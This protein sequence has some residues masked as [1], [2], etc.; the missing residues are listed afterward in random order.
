MFSVYIFAYLICLTNAILLTRC[1]NI[2]ILSSSVMVPHPLHI[3]PTYCMYE[4]KVTILNSYSLKTSEMCRYCEQNCAIPT[5]FS[6]FL[7]SISFFCISFVLFWFYRSIESL[8]HGAHMLWIV[9]HCIIH[10]NWF[11]S[12]IPQTHW[13]R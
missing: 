6:H 8:T 1:G 5:I 10:T 7:E 4:A 12:I 9:I 3:H 13:H 11:P 2:L